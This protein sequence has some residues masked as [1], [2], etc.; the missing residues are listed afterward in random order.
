MADKKQLTVFAGANGSGKSTVAKHFREVGLCPSKFICPDQ[1]VPPGKLNDYDA[2]LLAMQ[3]AE[4]LRFGAITR[5]ESFSFETVLSTPHKL[6]FIRFAK[7]EGYI[8]T[9]VYVVTSSP[10]INLARIKER[11]AC[12]G[13][14]VPYEKVISR[15]EK[16][17]RLMFPVLEEAYDA[18]IYDNSNLSP[19]I[20]FAKDTL[21]GYTLSHEHRDQSWVQKYLVSP[22][23]KKE[24]E[25]HVKA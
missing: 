20:V 25:I 6:D 9:A 12:G 24:I 3:S 1:L 17:M 19:E 21:D 5:S 18:V 15:Y 7:S 4:T 16:S 8:I 10:D 22:A 2:Y 11:V 23:K 14:D 13:H